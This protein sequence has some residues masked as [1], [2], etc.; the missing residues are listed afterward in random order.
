MNLDEYQDY[1]RA[2]NNYKLKSVPKAAV[3]LLS[4]HYLLSGLVAQVGEL[5]NQFK[6]KLRDGDDYRLF[7]KHVS[8]R[9]GYAL[10]YLANLASELGLSLEDIATANVA[11]NERRW[12]QAGETAPLFASFDEGFSENERLP[13][14]LVVQFVGDSV[15]SPKKTTMWVYPEWPSIADRR[16]VGAELDDNSP[17]DDEYR[18]HD[19]FHL[20]FMSVL[21]WS[22][23]LRALLGRKRKSIASVDRDQD[24]GRA[25]ITE[26]AVSAF[27]YSYV[28]SQNYLKTSDS[29][30]TGILTTVRNLVQSYEVKNL[31][32]KDWQFSILIAAKIL[33]SLIKYNGG[34]VVANR[35]RGTLRYSRRPPRI[36]S[37][38]K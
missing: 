27:I 25:T 28:Y 32:E 24:G 1:A 16:R 23:V 20:A 3:P 13:T 5:E 22:P 30:D 37:G 33:R 18:F 35:R 19:I 15:A 14:E 26:E 34:W 31:S 12:P 29:V 17:I 4:R 11:F 8:E 6:K 38:S 10:W 7:H 21:S 9:L 36:S 2:T